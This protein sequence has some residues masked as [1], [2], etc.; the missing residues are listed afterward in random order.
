M[1]DKFQFIVGACPLDPHLMN[2]ALQA[3]Q[4][5]VLRNL[6]NFNNDYLSILFLKFLKGVWGELR[7]VC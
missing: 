5:K 7:N 4:K 6:K 3:G 2:L 1:A